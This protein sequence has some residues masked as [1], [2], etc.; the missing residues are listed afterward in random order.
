MS[1]RGSAFVDWCCWH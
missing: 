1:V